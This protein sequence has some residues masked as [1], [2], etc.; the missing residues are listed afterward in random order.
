MPKCPAYG[1]T[2]R[3]FDT[4]TLVTGNLNDVPFDFDKPSASLRVT[5]T[6]PEI[7][8]YG[9][10]YAQTWKSLYDKFDLDFESTL[11]LSQ[12][13]EYWK[14]YLYF[15]AGFFYYKC[16][17]QFGAS[18]LATALEIRDNAPKELELQTLDP[19]LDQVALPIVI[20]GLGGGRN[21]LEPGYLDGKTTCHY[22]VLSLL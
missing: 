1:G 22:R 16:P 10:G 2:I 12:P 14:R 21:A 20:H 3:F 5:G 15:N 7:E 13:D 11:D 17:H 4:D 18:F 6:W 8:L 9:P 19:W